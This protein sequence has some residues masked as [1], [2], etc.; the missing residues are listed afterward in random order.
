M[1]CVRVKY[2]SEQSSQRKCPHLIEVAREYNQIFDDLGGKALASGKE[3]DTLYD[4]VLCREF[5]VT[6]KR[7]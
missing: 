5:S 3:D 4:E 1:H 6:A 7:A 2:A